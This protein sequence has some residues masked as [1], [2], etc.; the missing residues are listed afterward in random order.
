MLLPQGAYRDDNGQP[1]VL[2]CVREAER[3]I[4]GNLNM[5]VRSP[6]L[7]LARP[8]AVLFCFL[9]PILRSRENDSFGKTLRVSFRDG[10]Y[11]PTRGL[12]FPFSSSL[13]TPI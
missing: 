2:D 1:V 8:P 10:I 11:D 4:A 7:L 5:S 12:A 3:R 9:P 6:P 13:L